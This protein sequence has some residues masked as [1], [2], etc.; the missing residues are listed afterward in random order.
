MTYGVSVVDLQTGKWYVKGVSA[1]TE[2]VGG[3]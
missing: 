2:A 1:S 3:Q